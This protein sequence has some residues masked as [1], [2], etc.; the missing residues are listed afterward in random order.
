MTFTKFEAS[1]PSDSS[2]SFNPNLAASNQLY[3]SV[4]RSQKH[5]G[6]NYA[7]EQSASVSSKIQNMMQGGKGSKSASRRAAASNHRPAMEFSRV[8]ASPRPKARKLQRKPRKGATKACKAPR[9]QPVAVRLNSVSK[10]YSCWCWGGGI[11]FVMLIIIILITCM[12]CCRSKRAMP[13][14]AFPN[15]RGGDE[16]S[17]LMHAIAP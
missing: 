13:I 10:N 11:T 12:C 17:Q 6:G 7:D 15:F 16:I 1:P 2:I 14:S 3:Q 4:V 9:R 5:G 8:S